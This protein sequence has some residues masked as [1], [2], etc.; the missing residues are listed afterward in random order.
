MIA[1]NKKAYLDRLYPS[2]VAA[3][4]GSGILPDTLI[5]QLVG[6][7]GWNL[8]KLAQTANNFHGIKADPSWN[9][10]VISATTQE[11]NPATRRNETFVGTWKIYASRTDAL[12]Q[13]AN[14]VT[15]FRAFSSP[16]DGFKGYVNF[17]KSNPRYSAAFRVNTPAQ[18]IVEIAKAGYA[19]KP[20]YANYLFDIYNGFKAYTS[21]LIK[22]LAPAQ[23]VKVSQPIKEVSLLAALI[24]FFFGR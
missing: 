15:L 4:K 20:T 10:R 13:G 9:G 24:G 2:A 7:S 8:S 23:P 1:Q 17:L 12:K 6:E 18:Q 3:T 22:T 5:T 21:Q 14:P 16:V 19:T 11:Y